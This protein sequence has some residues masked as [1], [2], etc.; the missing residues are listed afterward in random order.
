M[1]YRL[2]S[3]EVIIS[4]RALSADS[5]AVTPEGNLALDPLMTLTAVNRSDMIREWAPLL[6]EAAQ[7]VATHEIRNMGTLGGN[8]CQQTRCLYY[9]QRHSFQFVE[10][11]YKRAGEICYFIPKG[12]K[13]WAVFMA[14]TAPPLISLGAQVKIIGQEARQIPLEDFYTG[15]AEKPLDMA[16][17]EVLSQILIP[18]APENRGAA[19]YKSSL[20][21]GLEFAT[22]SVAA[23]LDMEDDGETCSR[24][25]LTIG[26][27]SAAPL[28]AW[29]AESDLT[30]KRLS[31]EL[32]SQA[33][34]QVVAEIRPVPHHGHSRAYLTECLRA[35]T[36]HALCS[37]AEGIKKN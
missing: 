37:A 2:D 35:G 3:P 10:P 17:G 16:S 1:K 11:C 19:F 18:R 22:L 25:R 20:R 24:A 28:R 29:K 21:G 8:L 31:K 23:V 12:K 7:R 34:D 15:V 27:V 9:N 4:L 32:F 6:S 5:P 36:R 26:A 30:G 14:D 33:A 13:C